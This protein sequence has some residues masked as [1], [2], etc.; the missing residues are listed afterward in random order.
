VTSPA[1]GSIKR[2]VVE[3]VVTAND[4]SGIM[5]SSLVA[6][7]NTVPYANWDN[8]VG[9][10]FKQSFDTN[11]LD[12]E[13]ELIQLTINI[14]AIDNVGNKT[15]PP[16]AHFVRL[17]NLPPLI[18]LDPPPLVES[19]ETSGEVYCSLP[20]DPVGDLAANDLDNVQAAKRFRALVVDQT[21]H[22]PGSLFDFH[23]GV[24]TQSVEMYTQGL[25]EVP[26]LVDTNNDG[27]CDAVNKSDDMN[28]RAEVRVTPDKDP[29]KI[30]LDA[31]TPGGNPW[32][33]KVGETLCD[34]NPNGS[35]TPPDEICLYTEMTR[36]VPGPI[37]GKP[38]AVYA[39]AP[40][41]S[42]TAGVCNGEDWNIKGN[43]RGRDGW[44]CVAAR[45]VDTI[46]NI[47]ISAPLRLCFDDGEGDPPVCNDPPPSCLGGCTIS[48]AQ[49]FEAGQI[50][51]FQ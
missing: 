19:T 6:T 35:D 15:D 11:E 42:P 25:L 34:N 50:W 24:D 7:I 13:H 39:F 14:T 21:N 51:L 27:I 28:I 12:P 46:G 45:A 47:G 5:P 32:F 8:N 43:T 16:V 20:F 38:P 49:K 17:D 30:K 18:S 36:V 48:D 37:Q 23:A 3:L 10:T 2:G 33:A 44:I 40:S 31:V 9:P 26:L 1:Y 4:P 41:N 29:V 22:A